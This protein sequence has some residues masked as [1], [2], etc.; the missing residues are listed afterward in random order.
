MWP[1]PKVVPLRRA[2]SA[3][4]ACMAGGF[5]GPVPACAQAVAPAPAST[6]APSAG[7]PSLDDAWWTG[8]LL[9]NSAG[10]LPPGHA[11]VEPYLYDNASAHSQGYGSRTYVL[12]GLANRLTVGVIP[13]LGYNTV[14]GGASSSRVGLGDFT[15]LAQYQLTQF[16]EG[17]RVPTVSI[18]VQETFPT[19]KYERLGDRPADGLGSGAHVTTLQVNTQTYFRLANGRL[20]RM[21][22]DV[23]QAFS[24]HAN[25]ADVSVYGTTPGFRGTARPG[26][27]FAADLAW[28]YSLTRNWVLALDLTYSHSRTTSVI[29]YV[30]GADSSS[31]P[32]PTETRLDS[33]SSTAF[34]FAP[35]VEYSWN[36]NVGA[37]F[38]VR[39][40]TGRN[41]VT[42]VTPVVALNMVY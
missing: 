31:A 18:E 3:L 5:P 39:V 37:I 42:T 17:S 35:A 40:I 8:P 24:S 25:V 36:A 20:L 4:L 2:I 19:G 6:P 34:G 38:G 15:L 10:T 30:Q 1:V 29:G 14:S 33:G 21:R 23:S 11:L 27:S 41:T 32:A 22:F 7:N 9:A 28:E 26:S 16:H 12:Y 13:V